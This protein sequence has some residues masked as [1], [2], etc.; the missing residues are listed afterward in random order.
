M[1]RSLVVLAVASVLVAPFGGMVAAQADPPSGM[2]VVA[3]WEMNEA[4]GVAVASDSGPNG[5]GAAVGSVIR[6]GQ[7]EGASTFYRYPYGP[8]NTTPA[9]TPRLVVADSAA[10]NPGTRDFSVSFT[11]RTTRNFGN[12]IQKGQHGAKGGYFKI[13]Q[14]KGHLTCLFRGVLPNGQLNG[15]LVNSGV[16]LDDGNWHSITCTRTANEV[17]MTIDGTLTRHTT[18]QSGNISNTVPLTIGGKTNCDQVAVTCDFFT[19]D[20]DRVEIDAVNPAP[21]APGYVASAGSAASGTTAKV[22]VPATVQP[23][24]L[25]LMQTSY[26]NTAAV[27][28]DPAGWTRLGTANAGGLASTVWWKLASL[29]DPGSSVAVNLSASTKSTSELLAY[30]G[31]DQSQPIDSF[32]AA[33]DQ[34]T[35]THTTPAV[36]AD[37]GDWAVSLW[38]D[39]SSSATSWGPPASVVTRDTRIGAG[40]THLSSL[41][42][43]SGGPIAA[44]ASGGV[45]ATSG[46]TSSRGTMWTIAVNMQ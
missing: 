16:L 17:T 14:P 20:I 13:E 9:D 28:A 35:S 37:P 43:D 15:V 33:I 41:S 34:N 11:Y 45:S 42:A 5:L 39:K 38:S 36:S 24:E 44:P 30:A 18:G 7:V 19:G 26:V 21:P 46:A 31:V 27:A 3:N 23:G 8:P 1:K 6:T 4:P 29:T 40:T 22:Q 10:L 25:L 12:I 2:S 32:A